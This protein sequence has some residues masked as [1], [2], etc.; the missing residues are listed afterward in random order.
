[1]KVLVLAGTAEARALSHAL[2]QIPGITV[3]VSLAGATARPADYAGVVRSGG[4]GG[5][6]GLVRFVRTEH[7][8]VVVDATHPFAAQMSAGVT[9]AAGRCGVPLLRLSRAAWTATEG[10]RWVEVDD[11]PAAAD[12]LQRLRPGCALLALGGRHLVPFG[13]ITGVRLVVRSVGPADLSS[14]SDAVMELGRGPF[15]VGGERA[16]LRRHGVGAVVARNSGGDDAKLIAARELGVPVIMVSRPPA[17][18][19]AVSSIDDAL[20][21]LRR[22]R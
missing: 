3:V 15:S 16:L 14:L 9:E 20:A 12:A 5:V 13:R 11:L 2:E 8:D 22:V 19:P 21:W 18:G 7:V 1:M 4:F 6:D 17:I 10:D